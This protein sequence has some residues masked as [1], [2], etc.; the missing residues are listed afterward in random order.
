MKIAT[1]EYIHSVLEE[2]VAANKL[3]YQE[4]WERVDEYKSRR[5][6]D[7]QTRK[8]TLKELEDNTKDIYDIY[9]R[10]VTALIDFEDEDF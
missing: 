9:I 7:R 5:D 2:D 10:A 8:Q 6:G 4:A 1:L 3:R